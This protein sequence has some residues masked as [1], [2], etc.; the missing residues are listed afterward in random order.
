MT[1]KFSYTISFILTLIIF[2]IVFFFRYIPNSQV[3][4]NTR[5]LFVPLNVPEQVITEILND[6]EISVISSSSPVISA[7]TNST[8][9]TYHKDQKKIFTD[10]N[11]EWNI[12]YL[13]DVSTQK[14]DNALKLLNSRN[15]AFKTDDSTSFPLLPPIIC[16]FVF[17]VFFVFS[18]K[19]FNFFI[20][21]LPFVFFAWCCPTWIPSVSVC[22]AFHPIFQLQKVWKRK[23]FIKYS[24]KDILSVLLFFT[25]PII[26]AFSIFQIF[27]LSFLTLI[28]FC[29]TSYL[30]Y[31]LSIEKITRKKN[32]FIPVLIVPAKK[33]EKISF[34]STMLLLVP[35][36]IIILSMLLSNKPSTFSIEKNKTNLCIPA[37]VK[38]TGTNQFTVSSFQKNIENQLSDKLPDLSDY[39]CYIWESLTYPYFSVNQEKRTSS[40]PE[41]GDKVFFPVYTQ[42]ENGISVTE[43][44]MYTFSDNFIAEALSYVKNNPLVFENIL[45]R[46]GKFCTI[47][48]GYSS[49]LQEDSF[50]FI[51]LIIA[52]CITLCCLL[53]SLIIWRKNDTK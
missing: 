3:W 52:L 28:S 33:I 53:Y 24:F 40:H 34:Q 13:P 30:L 15:I 11:N 36:C 25:F 4:K 6:C 7:E 51:K 48:Y 41:D 43:K 19:R 31:N 21:C 46:Q 23:G 50:I 2:L 12:F 1:K 20:Q 49:F 8:Y 29:C 37:P 32:L 38:Y 26:N 35:L 27:I 14:L 17:I 45:I 10:K 22:L 42:T 16:S 5:L 47:S 39:I 44:L 18:K 9:N